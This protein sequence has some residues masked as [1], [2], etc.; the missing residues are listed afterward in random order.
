MA[1]DH[2]YEVKDTTTWKSKGR[3][4]KT[5]GTAPVVTP[6]VEPPTSSTPPRPEGA[7]YVRYEDT[8]VTG[9][10]LQQT[11]NRVTGNRVLTFPEGEFIIPPNFANG[12]MDGIRV[13]NG[14]ANGC[15]GI[16]GSGRNT[17][18]KML[19]S[20][21][22]QPNYGA[23]EANNF[24]LMQANGENWPG[25]R[26]PNMEFQ[27]F[28]LQGTLLGADHDHN[29]LRFDSC[30]DFLVKDV[31]VNGIRGS[32]KIPPGET[33]SI[34]LFRNT[35]GLVKNTELDGR[36]NG[37][38]VSSALLMPNNGSNL[39][40]EDSYFHHTK[41]GGGGIAWYVYQGGTVRNTRSE[42]IGSGSGILNGYSFNH[43]QANN[44]VYYNPIMISDRNAVGG[45]GHMSLNSD[46]A[47]GGVDNTL[48]VYNPTWDAT[49]IGG[50][51]MF[52]EI[53]NLGA[54]QVQR[55]PADVYGPD[56]VTRLPYYLVDPYN[57]SRVIS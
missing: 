3:P 7:R 43:E 8:Y 28:Q 35:G 18:F 31:Y 1:N 33:G 17:I 12:Y 56:G 23:F 54:N 42:Y 41:Y 14:G 38:R 15:N 27:N 5:A 13:G 29:G 25:G 44:I 45:T 48:T 4:D 51:R 34:S 19:S 53:W 50:G 47:R 40:V 16:A 24:F 9:D 46:S 10:N 2:R 30:L 26:R 39:T 37:V 36:R 21:R 32:D 55:R 6:P 52:I 20:N 11:L 22:V 49:G 57:G